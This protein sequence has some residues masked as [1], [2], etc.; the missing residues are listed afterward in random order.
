MT[1]FKL[2]LRIIFVYL[3][4]SPLIYFHF[5]YQKS[6]AEG[7]SLILSSFLMTLGIS[8]FFLW[9]YTFYH[10]GSRQ[11]KKTK[12]KVWWFIGL[13]F[14]SVF[15]AW[16][17]YLIVCEFEYGLKDSKRDRDESI[18]GVIFGGFWRRVLAFLIDTVPIVATIAVLAYFCFGFDEV[19]YNWLHYPNDVEM[20]IEFAIFKSRIRELSFIIYLL[21]ATLMEAS[22]WQA[23]LGKKLVKLKVITAD[24][25]RLSLKQAFI[26]NITQLLSRHALFIGYIWAAFT[27]KKQG[28]HDLIAKTYVIKR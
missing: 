27:K 22:A 20:N 17:Y 28:W 4:I 11:F 24:N 12:Y 14:G 10:W 6:L 8:G 19:F 9:G 3:F 25:K 7:P 1:K 13:F 26:R 23:T 5:F 2:L 18:D 16:Y 21:Y 15:G